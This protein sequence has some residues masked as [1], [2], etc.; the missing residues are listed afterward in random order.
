M[1][2]FHDQEISPDRPA[3]F[4]LRFGELHIHPSTPYVDNRPELMKFHADEA[5][6]MLSTVIGVGNPNTD[7]NVG[8]QVKV[9]IEQQD[10]SEYPISMFRP[11]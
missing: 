5:F 2:S 7:I 10:E 9:E 8:R 11:V 3:A 1:L 6:R 4:A